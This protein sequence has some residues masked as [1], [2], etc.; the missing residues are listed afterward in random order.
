MPKVLN[1]KKILYLLKIFLCTVKTNTKHS[2]NFNCKQINTELRLISPKSDVSSAPPAVTKQYKNVEPIIRDVLS[3]D[4][5]AAIRSI[6]SRLL[7]FLL[8]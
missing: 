4:Q 6:K 1:V 8:T 7:G 2:I 3:T 5:Q